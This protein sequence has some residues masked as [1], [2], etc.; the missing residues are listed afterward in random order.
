MGSPAMLLARL[1]Q[2]LEHPA[3][4]QEA[5]SYQAFR[6]SNHLIRQEVAGPVM[7]PRSQRGGVVSAGRRLARLASSNGIIPVAGVFVP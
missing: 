5:A 6:R 1:F 2:T 4:S 3:A 7:A